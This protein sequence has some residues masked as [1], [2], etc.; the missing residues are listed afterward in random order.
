MRASLVIA[1][2][3][4]AVLSA[5]VLVSLAPGAPAVACPAGTVKALVGGKHICLKPGQKCV[6]RLD[7]VYHRYGFDCAT[8]KL[9]RRARWAITDLGT[10]GGRSS[11]ARAIN[12]RG[13]IVGRADTKAGLEHPFLS[14]NGKMRDIDALG[15][16]YVRSTAVAI[17]ER[18]EVVVQTFQTYPEMRSRTF[19]WVAGTSVELD[20]L[21]GKNMMGTAINERGQ[22]IGSIDFGRAFAWEQ[23]VT[24][25][26]GGLGG[27]FTH[28]T[29]TNAD[30]KAGRTVWR[31]RVLDVLRG[32]RK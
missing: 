17:N 5:S 31:P 28:A 32:L 12:D 30:G 25:D 1:S 7:E 27:T 8:G 9:T 23:G 26:L 2:V 13:Q 18:G 24:T 19:L 11:W 21:G 4:A 15:D 10:L 16:P 6:K 20:P 14:W 3:V 29:A 22:I